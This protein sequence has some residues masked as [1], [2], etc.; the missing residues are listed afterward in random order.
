[1][2]L[3]DNRKSRTRGCLFLSEADDFDKASP[4]GV[5]IWSRVVPN[6]GMMEPAQPGS[7]LLIGQ[8]PPLL[9]PFVS[10]NKQEY[11]VRNHTIYGYRQDEASFGS[12]G[13]RETSSQLEATTASPLCAE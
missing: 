9:V 2:S 3:L 13:A 6:H 4:L 7:L 8:P 1:M 5:T 12:V 10:Y 11:T